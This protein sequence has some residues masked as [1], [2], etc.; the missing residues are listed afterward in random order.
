MIIVIGAYWWKTFTM[1]NCSL[2]IPALMEEHMQAWK[3]ITVSWSGCDKEVDRKQS[4]FH[5][6]V[7]HFW[8]AL[9]SHN[10]VT[11]KAQGL[12]K[13]VPSKGSMEPV[14]KSCVILMNEIPAVSHLLVLLDD[15]A[16]AHTYEQQ[17]GICSRCGFL[18]GAY[19]W[20][21]QRKG[22][23]WV[24]DQRKTFLLSHFLVNAVPSVGA[25]WAVSEAVFPLSE[26]R[27]TK[28]AV[29]T[30]ASCAKGFC[31]RWEGRCSQLLWQAASTT[32]YL[33]ASS[34]CGV[35]H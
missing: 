7:S 17:K 24:V 3:F 4:A 22:R 14:N 29:E 27:G 28:D 12:C 9:K 32:Q 10:N 8:A 25:G 5:L 18:C 35:G 1:C 20:T 2:V 6:W 26:R 11:T 21:V 16:C 19:V 15:Q 30:E 33:C 13:N 31:P 34:S 23:A